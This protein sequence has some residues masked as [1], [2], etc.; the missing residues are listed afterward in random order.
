M[1]WTAIR[2][3]RV[4]VLDDHAVVRHG[5]VARLTQEADIEITGVFESGRDL[6]QALKRGAAEAD[7]LLMDYALGPTEIDGLNLIR[8][9]R[10]RY[11]DVKILVASAHHNKA[12]V[13]MAM[14]AGARGFVGKEEELSELVAAIRTVAT[15][16]KRLNAALAAEMEG[17]ALADAPAA[18]VKTGDKLSPLVDRPELSPRESEVLRCCLAGMSVTDIAEK[19]ARS[20]KTISSQKQSAYRKLG[21]QNDTELFKIKHEVQGQ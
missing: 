2:P 5:T 14:H 12:T 8:L 20:I 7:V 3:I 9:I 13:G 17:D 1:N 4:V 6:V 21:I 16:G 15:G 18:S 19:F 10:V 11:P